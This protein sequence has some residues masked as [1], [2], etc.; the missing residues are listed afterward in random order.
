MWELTEMELDVDLDS[1][2][3][4]CS[5]GRENC[6]T[7]AGE[8]LDLYEGRELGIHEIDINVEPYVGMEF[9]SEEAAMMYYDAYAKRL[10]FIIRVGNCHRSGREGSVISPRYTPSSFEILKKSVSACTLYHDKGPKPWLRKTS[11][12]AWL[13]T[14][15]SEAI[16]GADG[17]P[18]AQGDILCV[19]CYESGAL[20]IFDV[21]S[22]NCAISIKL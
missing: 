6:V 14:G 17:A 3:I 11:T 13:S 2:I 20:E 19:V 16:D 22:F 15:I 10:G 12:D 4:E 18:H 7:E 21:P 1:K 8:M 9:E 5:I